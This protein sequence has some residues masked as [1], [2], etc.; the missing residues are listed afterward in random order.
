VSAARQL[1]LLALAQLGAFAC[2][3][4]AAQREA[5]TTSYVAR[6]EERLR[7]ASNPEKAEALKLFDR[8]CSAPPEACEVQRICRSAYN[9]HVDGLKLK[10][11][12]KSKMAAGQD[13]EAAKLLGAAGDKL[14]QAGP[15]VAECTNRAAQLR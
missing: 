15:R 10:D 9:L 13:L 8:P 6:S 1:L 3:A 14:K 2:D 4:N 11:V 7:N 5:E 12:A